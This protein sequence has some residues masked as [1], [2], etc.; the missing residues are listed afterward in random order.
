MVKGKIT[1]T[2]VTQE[3]NRVLMEQMIIVLHL[4]VRWNLEWLI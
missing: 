4:V 2:E 1:L 3:M